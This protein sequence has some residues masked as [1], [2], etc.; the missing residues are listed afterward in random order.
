M[1]N[2]AP[3]A[4]YDDE[5]DL[6]AVFQTLW[7]GR[8]L[9]LTLTLVAAFVAYAVSAWALPKQYEATAYVSVS[10]PNIY[11]Q[12]GGAGGL[13]TTTTSPDSKALPELAQ[14]APILKAVEGDSRVA[15]LFASGEALPDVK[16]QASLVGTSQLRFQVT[17]TNPQRAATIATVWAEKTVEWIEMNYGLSLIAVSLDDQI[18]QAQ[19]NYAAAQSD[20]ESF[21]AQD[22]TPTLTSQLNAQS[23]IYACLEKRGVAARA[24]LQRLE[25]LKARLS[26]SDAPISLSDALLMDAIQRDM[27]ALNA[28]GSAE[29]ILQ[30]SSPTAWFSGITSSQGVAV[31]EDFRQNLKQRIDSDL[32]DQNTLQENILKLQVRIEELNYQRAQFT[33][34]RDRVGALYQQLAEQ[35]IMLKGAIEQNGKV[36]NVSAE[37]IAPKNASSPRPLMNAAIA[38]FLGLALGAMWVLAV[39]WWK[40]IGKPA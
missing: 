19:K 12:P 39:D 1:Q 11:Y 29:T 6:R 32:K 9:I 31:I 20:L 24:L 2:P 16:M 37:A 28:C 30:S 22:Q 4:L 17:N 36:A 38:G 14:A 8:T 25:N 3:L 23:E 21:L 27:D 18:A 10:P 7:K 5:I 34:Q 35:Q 13:V 15:S 40:K 26:S 33:N